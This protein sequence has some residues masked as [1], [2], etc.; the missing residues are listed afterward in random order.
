MKKV[1]KRSENFARSIRYAVVLHEVFCDANLKCA[2][3][4]L[5]G[6]GRSR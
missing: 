4:F 1:T 2:N 3:F 5:T 6:R